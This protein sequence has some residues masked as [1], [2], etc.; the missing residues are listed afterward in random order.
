MS[1]AAWRRLSASSSRPCRWR[2]KPRFAITCPSCSSSPSSRSRTSACS[3]CST[4]NGHAARMDESEC[5]IVQRERFC[6]PV[7][8]VAHDRQRGEMLLG[9]PVRTPVTPKLGSELVES[10]RSLAAG[11]V[12]A[13]SC[14]CGRNL[15]GVPG[16]MSGAVARRPRRCPASSSSRDDRTFREVCSIDG[17]SF[18][19]VRSIDGP[20]FSRGPSI[21]GPPRGA[22]DRRPHL[23]E[24]RS[25][26]G[27]AATGLLEPARSGGRA[28]ARSHDR[29]AEREARATEAIRTMLIP[30]AASI[31]A[32]RNQSPAKARARR[33]SCS[34]STGRS[35]GLGDD[36]R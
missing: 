16:L 14:F 2:T 26:G 1:S 15:E 20:H 12:R 27:P 8:E 18:P 25:I 35:S 22:L 31:P 32:S 28:R 36:T 13:G 21:D 3:K 6:A 34:R 17:R 4:A 29:S 30:R 33:R 24:A 10:T 19:E 23:R 11:R 7:I 9:G 5:E